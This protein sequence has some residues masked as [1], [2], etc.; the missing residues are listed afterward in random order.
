MKWYKKLGIAI[1]AS[2][3]LMY[4][5]VQ[6]R[7]NH[8]VQRYTESHLAEIAKEQENKIGIRHFGLPRVLYQSNN[9]IPFMDRTIISTLNGLFG[10]AS[11]NPETDE[12]FLPKGLRVTPENNLTNKLSNLIY[13][14]LPMDTKRVLS[15]ELGHYYCDKLNE[16]RGKGN[17]APQTEVGETL[18]SE[19]IAEYF[20]YITTGDD[21]PKFNDSEWPDKPDNFGKSYRYNRHVIYDGGFHLVKPIIDKYGKKGITY[22]MENPP[23]EKDLGDVSMYQIKVLKALGEK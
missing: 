4:P 21:V 13:F 8:D 23:S 16:S 6:S 20:S 15:H 14:E 1:L 3:S 17:L 19:G 18:V 2:A 9:H 10:G 11:Y 7:I 22:L 5:I 12:I